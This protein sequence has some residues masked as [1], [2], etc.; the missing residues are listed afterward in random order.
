MQYYIL[1]FSERKARNNARIN[2]NRSYQEFKPDWSIKPQ[3]IVLG[4]TITSGR[5]FIE[6]NS[7]YSCERS[8]RFVLLSF[9]RSF[10]LSISILQC[11]SDLF[12]K[13]Y[14]SENRGRYRKLSGFDRA[15]L[16]SQTRKVC[17]HEICFTSSTITFSE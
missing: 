8:S 5:Q 12:S 17:L 1:L 6:L 3:P 13:G 9:H 7:R 11:S 10:A 2:L 15:D 14:S 4:L 16:V